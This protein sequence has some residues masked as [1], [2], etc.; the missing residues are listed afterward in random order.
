MLMWA[1]SM[2]EWQR[3]SHPLAL[4]TCPE[5]YHPKRSHHLP[6][7][8]FPHSGSI[9]FMDYITHSRFHHMS[10]ITSSTLALMSTSGLHFSY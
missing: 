10:W 8:L 2:Q 5:L 4:C 1:L 7:L 3:L 9:T 6:W